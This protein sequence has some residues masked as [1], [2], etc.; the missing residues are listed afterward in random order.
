MS[1]TM[2]RKQSLLMT[3]MLLL[4][5]ACGENGGSAAGAQDQFCTTWASFAEQF[6]EAQNRRDYGPTLTVGDIM[7]IAQARTDYLSLLPPS[8]DDQVDMSVQVLVTRS[9]SALAQLSGIV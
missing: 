7:A 4:V 6:Q 3:V 1:V 2:Y 5:G 8:G 9:Q